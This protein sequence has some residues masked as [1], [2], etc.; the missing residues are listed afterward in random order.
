LKRQFAFL[1]ALFTQI[2]I[3]LSSFGEGVRKPEVIALQWYNWMKAGATIDRVGTSRTAFY[4][5]VISKAEE[6][7]ALRPANVF[8]FFQH[9]LKEAAKS[10]LTR[11]A[12][13]QEG[14]NCKFSAIVYFDE[15]HTFQTPYSRYPYFAIMHALSTI[16]DL[17]IF[18]IFLSTNSNLFTFPPM[19]THC[20]TPFFR[21]RTDMN[22]IPPFFELPFD[23]FCRNFTAE[24]Q[25][26]GDLTLSGVCKLKHMTKFG[27]PMW[28]SHYLSLREEKSNDTIHLAM[29]KLRGGGDRLS[30]LARLAS[31]VLIRFDSVR[32]NSCSTQADLVRSC[33]RCV[34]NIPKGREY[35]WSGFPS[36]PMLSEAAAYLLNYD[37]PSNSKES[38]FDLA[39]RILQDA[40]NTDIL[41]KGEHGELVA[42][43]LLTVAHDLAILKKYAP[44][45]FGP[46]F[47]RPIRL[48]DLLEHLMTPEI[49][50]IVRDAPPFD[51]HPGNPS[52]EVAFAE[53]WV[54][55]S[56]FVLLGDHNSLNLK[57]AS[58]LLKRGA[59]F[60]TFDNQYN[61]DCGIPIYF[62][63]PDQDEICE[64]NT[65]IAQF[66]VKSVVN[67]PYVF[68]DATLVGPSPTNRPILSITMQL[69]TENPAQR[70]V[71]TTK[72]KTR[73]NA[74]LL[75]DLDRR[76]YSI[77][78]RGCRSDTYSCIPKND[79]AIY[80]LLLKAQNPFVDF[81]RRDSKE[82]V[83]LV[84]AL[85]PMMYEDK[86]MCWGN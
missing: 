69:G 40:L 62:G 12:Q 7:E 66:Q 1:A 5:K 38:I 79:S 80:N 41:A 61:Q 15:A 16:V 77:I 32:A 59:A 17:P 8:D 4:D 78:L 21:V 63:D 83:E 54:N 24:A 68:P 72:E 27:R 45:A 9:R 71:V 47:H 14:N 55:F 35:V 3:E 19:D 64:A 37:D 13:L 58:A 86:I 28:H 23:T 48:L 34:F 51:A 52:L 75:T 81:P 85:K 22:L 18:F 10:F 65:S 70:V 42:Q 25:Q 46:R 36:E 2:V 53:A 6:L 43:T 60:Q 11:L 56:H 57:F 73:T 33:M 30:R 49:W 82:N 20:P 67:S 31:R 39:P 50:E 44:R 74:S 29:T 76:H 84:D 26:A